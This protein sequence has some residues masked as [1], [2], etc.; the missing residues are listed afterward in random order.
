M[1]VYKLKKLLL[2]RH[3]DSIHSLPGTGD[4]DR[5]LSA[6]GRSAACKVARYIFENNLVPD[7][8]LLSPA[9][10]T[11]QA[12]NIIKSFFPLSVEVISHDSLYRGARNV[13][14]SLIDQVSPRIDR[15]LLLGHNP[16]IED[17][18]L[19]FAKEDN[20][21][22]ARRLSRNYPTCGLSYFSCPIQ[23]W[24][25]IQPQLGILEGFYTPEAQASEGSVLRA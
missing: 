14:L 12:F 3:P 4:F 16:G 18:A 9:L 7:L 13:L 23:D 24:G 5:P 20:S 17:V 11:R 8:V 6:L 21:E 10:R 25:Q 2:L 22:D 1:K 19:W 15:I